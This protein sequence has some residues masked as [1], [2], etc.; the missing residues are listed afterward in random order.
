MS[1]AALEVERRSLTELEAIIERGQQTFVEVGQALMEIRD[2]RLYKEQGH[3]T[4][5]DYC[6]KRWGWQRRH[7]YEL[8]QAAEVFANVRSN[9][10]NL[11][12]LTQAVQLAP[13]PPEFPVIPRPCVRGA[14]HRARRPVAAL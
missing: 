9:A 7:G 2:G 5:E 3:A 11:P 12:S 14:P 10:Q 13:L 1:Q 6:Q 4:F 8:I